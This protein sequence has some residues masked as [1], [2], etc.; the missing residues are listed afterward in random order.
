LAVGH[1]MLGV[2]RRQRSRTARP[3][4]RVKRT[5]RFARRV[6]LPR[7]HA[8]HSRTINFRLAC[9]GGVNSV[10]RCVVTFGIDALVIVLA[11]FQRLPIGSSWR[12]GI[13]NWEW[14]GVGLWEL[15]FISKASPSRPSPDS[16]AGWSG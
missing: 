15:G 13:G 3:C 4:N 12:L 14:L 6:S 8:G 11:N 7:Q 16:S 2:E 1:R 5:S 9:S 10:A